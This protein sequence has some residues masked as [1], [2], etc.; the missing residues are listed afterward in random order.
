MKNLILILIL[1]IIAASCTTMDRC[2]RKYPPIESFQ[3]K[4]SI[5][6]NTITIYKDSLIPYALDP[7][8]VTLITYKYYSDPVSPELISIDTIHVDNDFSHAWAWVDRSTLGLSIAEKDTTLQFYLDSS[9]RVTQHFKE[10]YHSELR[11]EVKVVTKIPNF[12]RFC[13]SWFLVTATA[14]IIFLILKIKK[15]LPF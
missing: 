8:T 12:Y 4:D 2:N 11:K 1:S 6:L 10:L 9:V 7:D 3:I 13:M 5:V 15:F 14:L